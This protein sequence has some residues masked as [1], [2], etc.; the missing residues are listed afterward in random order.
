MFE[1]CLEEPRGFGASLVNVPCV[2]IGRGHA[3]EGTH[4]AAQCM[5]FL[6]LSFFVMFF[7]AALLGVFFKE[8]F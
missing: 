5:C 7:A 8:N 6:V 3:H 4:R 2:I 1:S